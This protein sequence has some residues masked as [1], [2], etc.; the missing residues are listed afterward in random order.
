[1]KQLAEFLP[2]IIFFVI[3][4]MDGST[5]ALSNWTHTVD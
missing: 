2:I 3:Y 1:M 4:Q 5:I